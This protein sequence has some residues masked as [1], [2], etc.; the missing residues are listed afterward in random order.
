MII[1]MAYFYSVFL[2]TLKIHVGRMN[3]IIDVIDVFFRDVSTVRWEME[4]NLYEEKHLEMI[5]EQFL[6]KTFCCEI[7]IK[8]GIL[9][10]MIWDR[11]WVMMS[12][13]VFNYVYLLTGDRWKVVYLKKIVWDC[14][15]LWNLW[16]FF[17]MY[18]VVCV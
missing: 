7:N 1:K 5:F 10:G 11:L 6:F 2:M 9:N 8:G 12:H 15:F 4:K 3:R 17:R 14:V 18:E 16:I 13:D